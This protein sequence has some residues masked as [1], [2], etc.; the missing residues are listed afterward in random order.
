[1]EVGDKHQ[2]WAKFL[3]LPAFLPQQLIV[4]FA[5]Q[6]GAAPCTWLLPVQGLKS[7]SSPGNQ[8]LAVISSCISHHQ[9]HFPVAFMQ[10]N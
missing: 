6:M 5:F 10:G 9:R 8:T 4:P 2:A 1:M 7:E 3:F